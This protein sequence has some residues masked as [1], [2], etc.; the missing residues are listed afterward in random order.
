MLIYFA[1]SGSKTGTK[2]I[3]TEKKL[4]YGY[5]LWC[6]F[7][8]YF[9]CQICL[10]EGCLYWIFLPMHSSFWKIQMVTSMHFD[11]RNSPLILNLMYHTYAYVLNMYIFLI[12]YQNETTFPP[13]VMF[14]LIAT[15]LFCFVPPF[16]SSFILALTSN[17]STWIF[18]FEIFQPAFLAVQD[19]WI[20][21]LV[22]HSLTLSVS[23]FWFYNDYKDYNY[24]N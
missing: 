9:L 8:Y 5:V 21:D 23:H 18:N 19:R 14:C 13:F 22:T 10:F 16:L 7:V 20:G 4:L 1:F 15:H 3:L 6:I 17:R 12:W 24:Y 2:W 11:F